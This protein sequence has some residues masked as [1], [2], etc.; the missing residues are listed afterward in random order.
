MNDT[1]SGQVKIFP[2]VKSSKIKSKSSIYGEK[3]KISGNNRQSQIDSINSSRINK[4]PTSFINTEKSSFIYPNEESPSKFLD[5]SL[6]R[7]RI[8]PK[9]TSKMSIMKKSVTR[10][11]KPKP[12]SLSKSN[13]AKKD[14]S[15]T[16][17]KFKARKMPDMNTPFFIFKNDKELTTF[18]EFELTVNRKDS[19]ERTLIHQKSKD[20][21]LRTFQCLPV[22]MCKTPEN[23]TDSFKFTQFNF[24]KYN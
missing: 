8:L 20:N 3:I 10:N 17:K 24:S 5:S 22:K 13:Y 1:K 18:K 15:R 6:K 23:R 4:E 14:Q 12:F 7:C 19:L 21:L 9:T 11:T 16:G 2:Q